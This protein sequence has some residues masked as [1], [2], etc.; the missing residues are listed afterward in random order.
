[1]CI[2]F[3][4][5]IRS[6]R[7]IALAEGWS[8]LLLL[9]IAMPLKYLAGMPLAVRIVGSIHGGLFVLYVIAALRA[10]NHDKWSRRQLLVALVASVLPFGPFVIDHKLKEEIAADDAKL[11]LPRG[12]AE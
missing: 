6:F 9:G 7:W 8:F 11:A 3:R 2:V 5:P 4:D 1:V 12:S 10:A